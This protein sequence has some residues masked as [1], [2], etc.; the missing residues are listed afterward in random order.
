MEEQQEGILSGKGIHIWSGKGKHLRALLLNSLFIY[1]LILGLYG[2]WQGHTRT[3]PRWIPP[4]SST[5]N[6]E[7]YYLIIFTTTQRVWLSP[8]RRISADS[9]SQFPQILMI[10]PSSSAWGPREVAMIFNY[11]MKMTRRTP[12]VLRLQTPSLKMIWNYENDY[13]VLKKG[14]KQWPGMWKK[15]HSIEKDEAWSRGKGARREGGAGACSRLICI[16]CISLFQS[17]VFFRS[18]CIFLFYC[19]W[20]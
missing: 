14:R 6:W 15:T 20:T 8:S 16:K 12:K 11:T 4:D 19:K 10:G 9:I 13:T 7:L 17:N 2:W 18:R 5:S 1:A 3:A